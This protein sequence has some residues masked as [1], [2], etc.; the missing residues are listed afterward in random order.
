MWEKYRHP[1]GDTAPLDLIFKDFADFAQK[2]KKLRTKCPIDLIR[3]V[4][5]ELKN[6]C[7]ISV[8]TPG[9]DHGYEV[10]VNNV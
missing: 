4:S 7:F 8:E 3:N 1:L 5:K 10:S 2:I 9:R 6:H